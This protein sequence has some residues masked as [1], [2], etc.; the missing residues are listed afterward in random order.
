M[1][2]DNRLNQAKT[3]FKEIIALK[4]WSQIVVGFSGGKDSTAVLQLLL[5]V[6]FESN[7]DFKIPIY[8]VSS[9][10]KVEN[11]LITNRLEI[12]HK[13]I[14]EISQKHNLNLTTIMTRPDPKHSFF[15]SVLALGY[16]TPLS[17]F[18]RWC[19]TNLKVQPMEKYYDTL[20]GD[21]LVVTGVRNSESQNRSKK[22]SEFFEDQLLK[23]T[24]KNLYFYAPIREFTIEDVWEYIMDILRVNDE[25]RYLNNSELW[26]LYRDGTT[27][28][29]CPS[30]V[31]MTVGNDAKSCGSSRYGCYLCPLA[32]VSALSSN[33]ENGH[34]E[35][36][37]YL[38]IQKYYMRRCYDARYRER[39]RRNG[40][41][42]FKK[43]KTDYGKINYKLLDTK[44]IGHF[45]EFMIFNVQ[46]EDEMREIES[47]IDRK[48]INNYKDVIY[49][50]NNEAFVAQTGM[51]SMSFR[52]MFYKFIREV[53]GKYN[54]LLIQG[55]ENELITKWYEESS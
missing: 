49:L 4:K 16:A 33:V 26:E 55:E 25:D 52:K 15:Y 1:Y 46:S 29:V 14:T 38:K 35:L 11:P 3:E 22:L 7:N 28:S 18:G 20:E 21:T 34:D 17:G 27:D 47:N 8:V 23:N 19:T 10:T 39:K 44:Y 41:T 45:D 12:A 31:D 51:L 13:K 40:I 42:Y 50:L 43:I 6:V 9:D 30:S 32:K 54:I 53:E 48:R 37:P 5:D 24:K 2:N 36:I